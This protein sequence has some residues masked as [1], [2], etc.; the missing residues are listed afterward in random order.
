MTGQCTWVPSSIDTADTDNMIGWPWEMCDRSHQSIPFANTSRIDSVHHRVD[1]DYRHSENI[2]LLRSEAE[3]KRNS[4]FHGWH[5]VDPPAVAS[6]RILCRNVR[7]LRP[8]RRLLCHNSLVRREH[9]DCRSLY[10]DAP[11]EDFVQHEE[12]R[13]ACLKRRAGFRNAHIAARP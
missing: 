12:R 2:R 6:G 7:H 13:T 1:L 5:T 3:A 9:S 4:G 11:A 10:P 8:F